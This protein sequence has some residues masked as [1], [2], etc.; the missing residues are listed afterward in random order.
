MNLVEELNEFI[1]ITKDGREIK[2]AIAV[3][4]NLQG[5]SYQEIKSLLNV[6]QSFISKWKSQVGFV[7]SKALKIQ[8]KGSK[9]YLSLQQKE[10]IVQWL[11]SQDYGKIEKLQLHIETKYG[12]IFQSSQSYYDLMHYAKMSWKKTQ[13]MNPKKDPELVKKNKKQLKYN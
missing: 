7:G 3:K 5:R 8:Y 13:K 12:V 1:K 9:S 11:Q 4:M 2:R 10:E 6:S